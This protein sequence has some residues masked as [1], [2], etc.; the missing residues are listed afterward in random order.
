MKP[1]VKKFVKSNKLKINLLNSKKKILIAD[2]ALPEHVVLHSL[3]GYI[4]NKYL[5][6]D[7]EVITNL[8]TKNDLIKIYDSF[9]IKKIYSL[10]LKIK[11][12]NFFLLTRSFF[13]FFTTI[14]KILL[15]GELW[16]IKKFSLKGVYLG[17]LVYDHYIRKD[18]SFLNKS[19]FKLKFFKLL[20]I[21]IYE[22]YYIDALINK[23]THEAIISGTNCYV[24]ISAI[25]MRVALKKKIKVINLISNN[26]RV[27][28]HYED[29]L[30]SELY[31]HKNIIDKISNDKSWKRKFNI[32]FDNILKKRIIQNL[33]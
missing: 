10:Q 19:F 12:S 14:F 13:T 26:L 27:F 33:N 28:R 17:D 24:S 30:K 32:Y 20:L 16:F 31:I 15:F 2:R 6:Y 23:K 8:T 1:E 5:K 29:S 7:V 25:A 9:N 3:A 11:F 18:L 22:F 21:A 4:F